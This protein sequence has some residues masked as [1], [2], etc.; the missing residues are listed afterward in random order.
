MPS[1]AER[2][3][4][5]QEALLRLEKGT[6]SPTT[7][8]HEAAQIIGVDLTLCESHPEVHRDFQIQTNATPKE[9]WVLRWLLKR[10]RSGKNYRVDAASFL[11]LRQLIDLISPKNLA[12]ILKDQKF[13]SILCDT[14]ED[15]E[16]DIFSGLGN[17]LAALSSDSESSHT[18]SG[19]PTP[20][21]RRGTQGKKRKRMTTENDA[22]AMDVDTDEQ[23]QN[24]AACFLTFIRALDCLH[25]FVT[26]T[27][28]T[29][30]TD[31]VANSHLKLALRGEPEAISMLLG[32][33]F[34]VAAV[35]AKQ[36]SHEGKTTDLQHLLY[37]FPSIVELWESRS[38]R[39][40]DMD[41]KSSNEFFARHCFAHALRLQIC[42]RSAK[43]DT[44]E[45]ATLLHAIE[46]II[47]LHVLLPARAAFFERGSSGIDYS[48]DEPDW[49]S[50]KPVTDTFRPIIRE[51]AVAKENK[52]SNEACM[53]PW[54]SVELLPELFDNAVRAVPR[55]VFRRQTHEAPWLETLFV[56]V[57]E[58]AFSTAKEED[59]ATFSSKFISVLE[60]LLQ[61]ALDRK[62]GLSLHTI[63][64][65]ANYTGLFEQGLEKVQW[66][67]TALFISLGVDIFLP[68]SGLRDSRK[69]LDAL[70]DKILLQWR[71]T[72]SRKRKDYD[73]IKNKVVLPLL[74]GFTAARDLPTF[75][76][77]WHNQLVIVEEAR[78]D[79]SNLS[80]FSVW[81]DDE[82]ADAYSELMRTAL[83]EAHI[84][85]QMRTAASE[86]RAE[87]GKFAETPLSYAKFVIVE[88][89]FR[90]RVSMF[91]ESE[92]ILTS[93]LET[94]TSTL[95]SKQ[96]LHW[97]WRLWRLV[98]NFLE[99]SLQSADNAMASAIMP[100]VEVAAK[101]VHRNHKDLTKAQLA[102]LE[103]WE[104]YRFAIVATKAHA[105]DDQLGS[106]VKATK[107]AIE[108]IT[109]ISTKDAKKSIK[110]PWNGRTDTVDSKTTLGL[111][112]FLAL[113]RVPEVWAL[114]SSEDRSRLFRH[115]LSLAAAQY[116]S[117]SLPLEAVAEEA[118][119][120]QAWASVVCHEYMLNAPFI[121]S[122]L[123]L[124][125]NE[126]IEQDSS[127]RK[128]LI[129]SL[130][131]V[132]APLI[133]RGLRTTILNK[134]QNVL[135]QQDSS[136]EVTIG[137]ITMMAKLAAMPKCDAT[138]TSDWEPIWTAA[139]AVPLKGTD[140][141]LQIMKAFR[142]LHR[143][144]SAKLLVLSDDDRNKMFKKLFAR[145]SKQTAKMKQVDRDSMA[146][147]LLRLT[148]SELWVHRKQLQTAFSEKE[149]AD[150]REKVF[151]FVLADMKHVKDQCRK[152]KL[153]ETITLIKTIDA[154]EDFEDL[155]TDNVEV[156][157]F[158]SNIDNYMDMTV[159]SE[160]SR[161]IRRRLLATKGPEENIA[162]PVLQCA[163]TLA[164]QSLYAEDQQLFI[165]TT[166]ERFHSMT[167]EKITQTICEVRGL[168]LTGENA[169]YRLLVLYLAVSTLPPI[170]DKE[171][172][173]AREISL[174]CTS[175]SEAIIQS[176]SIDQFCF[177]SECL[178]LL[179]R[180]HTRSLT[181]CNIDGILSAIASAS[182][183]IG[184]QISPAYAPTIYTRLCRL[185]GV[186]LSLQRLKIGGRFHLVVN[187]MQRLLGC[188]FARSRKRGRS[189][190]H[191]TLSQPFWLAPLDASHATYYTRL[192]TSLCDPTV[193]A[194]LRPQPG[195][196]REALTDQTK[197]AKRI[198]GQYLQYVIMEYAQCSLRGSL[199]PEVKAAI[200]PGLY[201]ALDVTSRES[202]RALNA[203]LDVSGRAVFKS[204]YDDYVKFGKWNKG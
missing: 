129:E 196:S 200:L 128:L 148:L 66:N 160:P 161:L 44:D 63:L 69:L 132:P 46:R 125:L 78:Q 137:M 61:V 170:E 177:A 30:G 149:L 97:R 99:N 45:R 112:Y 199:S 194:V 98:R 95:S 57:A 189:R 53:H 85:A 26:L 130:Q 121:V 111:A 73:I 100:L 138:L 110:A 154:L 134:L 169:G 72:G 143:A 50:V 133:T 192:L 186:V 80:L 180:N 116:Q 93:L 159:D 115:I 124:L 92:T 123:S 197:K 167:V 33:A 175:L 122:D 171:S 182:S 37:V 168:G 140:L 144:V 142:S 52:A 151:D 31:G 147:F 173:T 120:L 179:L 176:T 107:D 24:P 198:A 68:N 32:R 181:Q 2:P 103:S 58:L 172:A 162:Q 190:F 35:A 201:A 101:T 17:A 119:F 184:P 158:L 18:L 150:C 19:S 34:R 165:R 84:A 131:R 118:K 145:A 20:D 139:R 187:A 156:E 164:L 108:L 106:F 157:K 83:T 141:D 166:T 117:S 13:L 55:D 102:P 193:S 135:L 113:V 42:L 21:D 38:Y 54:R 94:I 153:E 183:K 127:N 191:P 48:Q 16:A 188:L 81:E 70:L 6:A 146:C 10:L 71:E 47:A 64:A 114:I 77:I 178:D 96:A 51:F 109:T 8:I 36:F 14:F 90:G 11:L 7:Q 204:L 65:H 136:P 79:N 1:I 5:S 12:A 43:L 23:R 91:P 163:E 87:N 202:M 41:N 29:T 88:A 104:A 126:S 86:T 9:E 75:M 28:R 56:A 60:Q 195:A 15:L 22:D 174:L 185:M 40:D 155:A 82:L 203:A 39:E 49:S 67:V 152:Q 59:F 76:E 62:V 105:S 4:S 3:R 89:S 25:G 74:R 27:H